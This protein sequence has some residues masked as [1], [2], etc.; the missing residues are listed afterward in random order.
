MERPTNRGRSTWQRFLRGK[1]SPQRFVLALG[2]L[3]AALL[4]VGGVVT[5]V[6]VLLGGDDDPG[7]NS[8]NPV[9][10]GTVQVTNQKP[11]ADAFVTFLLQAAGGAPVQLDHKVTAPLGDGHY[12]LEY[13]CGK[14]T[15]CSF[16]RLETPA[17]I[18]DTFAGGVWFQ[19]CWSI[20]KDGA[21]YAAAHLDLTFRKQGNRCAS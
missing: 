5:G 2:A 13:D 14:S 12:R 19:G 4:A 1:T 21:G 16:V 11:S 15:G 3:A 6:A 10:D 18:P 7:S 20:T 17:D 8:A 9:A